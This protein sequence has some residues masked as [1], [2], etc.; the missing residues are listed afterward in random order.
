MRFVW[1]ILFLVLSASLNAQHAYRAGILPGIN[2]NVKLHD[3]WRLNVR[4][5]SRLDVMAGRFQ[6]TPKPG[7]TYNLTDLSFLVSKRFGLRHQAAAGYLLRMESGRMAH[8]FLQQVTFVQ[9][10]RV[11]RLAHR[12]FTDQTIFRN[13]K[14][15][16]RLRY[17]LGLEL[18]LQG[19]SV[20]PREFYVKFSNECLGSIQGKTPG[21][22]NRIIPAFG[23]AFTDNNKLEWG[24]DYRTTLIQGRTPFHSFWLSINW[25]VNI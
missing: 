10:Y 19:N 14:A 16:Y 7:F 20:D 24:F 25:F 15:I 21:Y 4:T 3:T 22:E 23:F 13:E 11:L 1:V 12:V 9:Q 5:E 18:P 17:R 6:E 2:V 8:R